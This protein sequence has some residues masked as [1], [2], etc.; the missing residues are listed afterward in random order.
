MVD[1]LAADPYFFRSGYLKAEVIRAIRKV[2]I[3]PAQA[4]R[5]RRVALDVLDAG[6]RREFR[7]YCRLARKV[8]S[9]ELEAEIQGRCDTGPRDVRRRAGWMLYAIRQRP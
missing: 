5:L 7:H 8:C 9:P 6:D 1:F 3:P 2:Q 4:D